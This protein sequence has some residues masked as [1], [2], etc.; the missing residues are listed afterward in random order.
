[1]PPSNRSARAQP[2]HAPEIVLYH[3]DCADGFGA[4]WAVWKRYPSAEFI[5][6]KHGSP[7]P[8]QLERR[9]ILIVDFTYPRPALEAIAAQ[10]ASL[11]VLDHHITAQKA[12]EGFPH[13]KFEEKKSG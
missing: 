1:M 9:H 11:L 13:A 7:P 2:H 8:P 3:A 4:A 5:P 12:L 6:V 10:A